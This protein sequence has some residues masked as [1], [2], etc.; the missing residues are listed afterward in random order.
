M[1]GTKIAVIGAGVMGSGIAQTAAT[2]G[3]ETYSFDISADALQAAREEVNNGRFGWE[4]GVQRGKLSRQDADAALARLHFTESLDEAAQ[5]DIIVECVPEKIGLKLRVFRDLDEK[6][7]ATSILATNTS[8]FSI[9]AIAAVTNRPERVIGWHWA[10]PPVVMKLAE[11]VV[12]DQTD[13]SVVDAIKDTAARCGK[14]PV[15]VKDSPTH[16][17]FVANRIYFAM[18]QEANR[19]VAEGVASPA[20]VNQLMVDCFRWPVG[21]LAMVQGATEGWDK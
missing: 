15:V 14:N 17:G 12:T 9:E 11:I 5:A 6:A 18:I 13:A 2:A 8:G 1:S 7:P 20:D 19:V 16:W 21:P 4:S 3:F 10:S